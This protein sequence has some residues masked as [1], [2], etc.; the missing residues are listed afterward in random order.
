M[1]T[2]RRIAVAINPEASFGKTRSVGPA[3]IAALE[4]RGAT[5]LPLQE[6]NIEL[7]RQSVKVRVGQGID[8][9][10]VVGGDGM[11]SL[12]ANALAETTI[13]LGIIPSGT[14]NDAARGLGIPIGDT[15]AA[16]QLLWTALQHGP[17]AIDV[18]VVRHGLHTT[19]F[20]G[21]LSA[22]F[23]AIVNERANTWA[24]PRGRSRY[25]LALIR[26][27]AV[28]KPRR[29][30]I[31][32]DG[33]TSERRA[34]L[35]AVANNGSL[36]GGMRA[37]PHASM[38]DGLLDLFVVAPLSRWRFL[39][40]FPRVFSGTHTDLDVVSFRTVSSVTLDADV[41]I[42]YADGERIGSLPVEV[43]VLQRALW[44]LA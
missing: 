28:L 34:V 41:L 12:A 31:T 33:V 10:V 8:A 39:R 9:L 22:G 4:A 30:E 27:L 20:V 1:T 15:D 29:Y 23:D 6:P 38:E 17:R 7:L 13:P 11:V 37:V 35:I 40:L 3:V 42:A 2:L 43:S 21:I 5:V 18:G 25:T 44:V 16:V 36:G 24:R 14:G 19:R 32:V 26:E